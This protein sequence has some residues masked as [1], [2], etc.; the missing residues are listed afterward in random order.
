MEANKT[1]KFKTN[2]NCGGCIAKVTPFL[3]G[4]KGI[5]NW[6]VDTDNRNKVLTVVSDG[7]T[8]NEVIDVV[9]K[10]GFKIEHID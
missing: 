5:G 1:L 9:Q 3:N 2:I 4:A 6:E 8:E 10:A 7:I